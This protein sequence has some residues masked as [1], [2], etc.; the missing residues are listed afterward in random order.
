MRCAPRYPRVIR[1]QRSVPTKCGAE[2]TTSASGHIEDFVVCHSKATNASASSHNVCESSFSSSENEL[3][4]PSLILY[5]D[6]SEH[7]HDK[8]KEMKVGSLLP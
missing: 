5:V 2:S 3:P 4:K 7:T 8:G 1:I 6:S